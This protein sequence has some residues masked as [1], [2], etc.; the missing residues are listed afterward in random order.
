MSKKSAAALSV[1]APEFGR[2]DPPSDLRPD[3]AEVWRTVVATK[4]ADWFSRDTHPLLSAYCRASC[5]SKAIA[6]Q[7][8][9]FD[10]EWMESHDGLMRY[11]RL[12][13]MQHRQAMVM[14]NLATKMRISQQSKYGARAAEAKARPSSAAKPWESQQKTAAR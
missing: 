13:A 11:N 12:M 9:A 8:D 3:E 6:K 4:P 10:P 14:A 1:V 7:V 2:P 5:S